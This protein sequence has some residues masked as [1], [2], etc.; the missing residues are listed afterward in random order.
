MDVRA[1]VSLQEEG[2]KMLTTVAAQD[3]KPV[4]LVDGSTNLWLDEGAASTIHLAEE[5]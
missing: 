5:L 1:S 3:R 4:T 2:G